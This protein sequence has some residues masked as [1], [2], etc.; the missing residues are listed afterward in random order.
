MK[1][2]SLL[3]VDDHGLVRAGLRALIDAL[4]DVHVLAE[5]G[6]GR[7]ALRLIKALRPDVAL[8]DIGMAG[9]NGLEASARVTKELPQVRVLMLSMHASEEYV[10]QALRSGAAGYLLKDARLAE[11]EIA[12]KA[13]AAGHTYLSPGVSKHMVAEYL[14]RIAGE[15]AGSATEHPY[16]SLTPRQRE[17]LQLIAEGH[18]TKDIARILGLSVKTVESYRAGLMERLD[19]HDI[20]GLVR[21]AIR[22]GLVS[23]EP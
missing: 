5:A 6:D 8:M 16:T 15:S 1:P 7:E 9:M 2:I 18:S 10:L 22:T 3:L 4:P 12:I 17:T 20:A 13:V 14:R 11:L 23:Q 21:Y 19:I